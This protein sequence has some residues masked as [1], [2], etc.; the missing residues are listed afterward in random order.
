MFHTVKQV[1]VAN[2]ALRKSHQGGYW[3]HASNMRFFKTRIVNGTYRGH[4]I[5]FRFFITSDD[6]WGLGRRFHIR[7]ALD[8]GQVRTVGD[9]HWLTWRA[10]EKAAEKL[11]P[12]ASPCANCRE[13]TYN[14]NFTCDR[15]QR[16]SAAE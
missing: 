4:L 10:A 14:P 15:C 2:R 13:E 5:H 1:K 9:T 3:F 12:D 8:N 16:E 11:L 7:A 6:V